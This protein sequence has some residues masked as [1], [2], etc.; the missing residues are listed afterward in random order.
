MDDYRLHTPEQVDITYTVAGLGSRFSALLIDTL[1]QG[2]LLLVLFASFLSS[3][4]KDGD[5]SEGYLAL[6]IIVV[7]VVVFGY[8]FIF[9]LLLRG[10]T[11]GKA[12][13]KIRVVRMDGRAA[14][15]PGIL[16]RNLVRLIDFLPACYSVGVITMFIHK[17]SR[18]LG[19]LAAGT[20]VIVERKQDSLTKILAEQ[21]GIVN[22]AL[23]NQEYAVLRDFFARRQNLTEE[24]RARLALSI[25][26]PLYAAWQATEEE[27]QDPERFL[28]R[29]LH[30]Q[31]PAC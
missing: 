29:V 15:V 26:S 2:L 8:F 27:K 16:L 18:R 17:E 19:D 12:L 6:F 30:G 28:Y 24:A 11:P 20:I 5:L 25:A 14:D 7:S 4:I 22:T 31:E 10:K 13:M 9:E 1:I 23:S 3:L 21:D